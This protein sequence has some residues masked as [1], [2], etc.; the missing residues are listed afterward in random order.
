M[1]NVALTMQ[2]AFR[3]ILQLQYLFQISSI[4]SYVVHQG[5]LVGLDAVLQD[6]QTYHVVPKVLGG[7]GGK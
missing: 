2:D 4:D 5:R 7:K 3:K 6:G 1:K